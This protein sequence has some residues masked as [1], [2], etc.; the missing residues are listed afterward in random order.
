MKKVICIL[1]TIIIASS[2]CIMPA[3]AAETKKDVDP[4]IVITGYLTCGL[5]TENGEEKWTLKQCIKPLIKAGLF[6]VTL[7]P[8]YY[9]PGGDGFF[10]DKISDILNE[11]F[12]FAI[13]GK[14][15]KLVPR[16]NTPSRANYK[17]LME[18]DGGHGISEDVLSEELANEIGGENVFMFS[19]D[20][21]KNAVDL[22]DELKDFIDDVL[23][24][25]GKSKVN[26]FALSYGGLITGTYLSKYG[27]D[28]KVN[29]AVLDVPALGGAELPAVLYKEEFEVKF[30]NIILFIL[31]A[32]LGYDKN[33][34]STIDLSFL[35]KGKMQPRLNSTS[36]NV[37]AQIRELYRLWGSYWDLMD[38]ENYTALKNKFL[39]KSNSMDADILKKSDELH[40]EIM[41]NYAESFEKCRQAGTKIS[42]L[43]DYT[44]C[45]SL[46]GGTKRSDYVLESEKVSGA[47]VAKLGEAFAADYAA[48]CTVCK[49]SNHKHISSDRIID[50]SCAYLPE[51]TWFFKNQH[52]GL[53][54]GSEYTL[55]LIK[56]LLYANDEINVN[57]LKDYPQFIE[58]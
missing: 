33:F 6:V 13:P 8:V 55:K 27:T 31:K 9:L 49:E 15:E 18:L 40:Y 51:N 12:E 20:W 14:G 17:A 42:V 2:V 30:G 19:Y 54:P 41:P 32:V 38:E 37:A 47:N 24:Y 21:R 52:H 16:D 1:L 53:Y 28:G 10:A 25:T 43:C 48:K 45:H 22:A 29:N 26:I 23:E 36:G 50:A 35:E 58:M 39:D 46:V 5:F 3:N 11:G 44:D 7:L 34:L 4:V 57:T 56:Q